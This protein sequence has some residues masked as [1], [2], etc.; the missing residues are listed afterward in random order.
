MVAWYWILV[1]LWVG[2]FFGG[3]TMALMASASEADEDLETIRRRARQRR[4]RR[5]V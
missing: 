4:L 3:G 2:V 1:A 5:H